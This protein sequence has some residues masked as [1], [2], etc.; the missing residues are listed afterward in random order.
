MPSERRCTDVCLYEVKPRSPVYLTVTIGKAQ[1]GG[2]CL[3]WDGKITG[4]GSVRSKKIGKRNEDLRGR[5]LGCTTRIKDVNP[6]TNATAV[7]YSFKGGKKP[8]SFRFKMPAA[9]EGGFVVY[10]IDFLFV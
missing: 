1:V 10:S 6:R 7:T 2:T 5:L 9:G 8:Q 4:E 3:H